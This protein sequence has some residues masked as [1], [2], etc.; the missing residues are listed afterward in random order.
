MDG[1]FFKTLSDNVI[2]IG[3]MMK[4]RKT[5]VKEVNQLMEIHDALDI[6]VD[7]FKN[8]VSNWADSL[9][10]GEEKTKEVK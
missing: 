2:Q 1:C 6:V 10:I 4:D 5:T 9:G 3:Q 7:Q 8:D